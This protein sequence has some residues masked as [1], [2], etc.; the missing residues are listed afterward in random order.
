MAPSFQP[1]PPLRRVLLE[2]TYNNLPNPNSIY[3]EGQFEEEKQD[4]DSINDVRQLEEQ[5]EFRDF[6]L[7]VN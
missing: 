7:L 3:E 1:P 4:L 2:K 6:V 5:M